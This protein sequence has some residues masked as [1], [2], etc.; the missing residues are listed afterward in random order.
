MVP[1]E[2]N[3]RG[4]VHDV[5]GPLTFLALFAACLTLVGRL[6]GAWRLYTLLT[7]AAGPGLTVGT[8][9]AYR[10]DGAFTGH[11]QRGLI[12]VYWSWIALQCVHLQGHVT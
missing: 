8:A 3:W 12:L 6:E 10:R 7:A 4:N 1:E 5:A 2:V 11:L 9:I